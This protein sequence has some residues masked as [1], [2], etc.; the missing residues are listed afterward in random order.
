MQVNI[1]DF[2]VDMTLGNK[3]ITLAIY[4]NDN[5]YLGKLRVGKATVEWCKGKTRIG[6]G[7]KVNWNDLITWFE[8]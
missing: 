4:G 5:Q 1:D 2:D 8:E 6:N 7:I 3:G